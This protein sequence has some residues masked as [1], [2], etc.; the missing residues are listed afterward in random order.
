MGWN[1]PDFRLSI[2]GVI[3]IAEPD[4][5]MIFGSHSIGVRSNNNT[6]LIVELDKIA[7]FEHLVTFETEI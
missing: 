4:S 1:R 2:L 6:K 5:Y 3:R 7:T